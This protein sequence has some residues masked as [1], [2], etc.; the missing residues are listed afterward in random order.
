MAEEAGQDEGGDGGAEQA[1]D[2]VD[3][4]TVAGGP[5]RQHCI[6]ARPVDPQYDGSQQREQV[7]GKLHFKRTETETTRPTRTAHTA[8]R[9]VSGCFSC[10]V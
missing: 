10:L 9:N 4:C 3:D 7:A 5:D 6:E 8:D 1:E 2:G